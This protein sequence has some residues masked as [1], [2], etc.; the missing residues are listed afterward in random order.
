MVDSGRLPRYDELPEI[1]GTGERHAWEVFGPNDNLGTVN[2]L[3]AERV[4]AAMSLA[5]AGRVI[6]LNLPLDLPRPA[7]FPFRP[8][9]IH[10]RTANRGGGDD[11][12]DSFQM[13][14]S[15]QWDGLRHI[16]FREH[17]YYQGVQ[18][19][20]LGTDRL[21]MEH[22][23][24]HGIF[25]RAVLIDMPRYARE[26]GAYSAVERIAAD[27]PMIERIAARE[28]V[29]IREGDILLLRT[30]WVTWYRGLDQAAR[31]A[32][33]GTVTPEGHRCA[34]V[35]P[36]QAT[37]AWVWNHHLAAIVA[38]NPGLEALP[39]ENRE[40]QHR[41]FIAMLGMPLGE[42][43]DLDGLADDCAQDGVYEMFLS[44]APLH[45]PGGV[46]SPAN[47]YAIK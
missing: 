44:A 46:G 8:A 25:G 33:V 6:N 27:G 20:A 38:D 34:G 16:R 24:R 14:G 30:G 42:L 7:L 23:A 37:A 43:W 39:V 41:R 19:D 12:L 32:L 28:Q 13:Q 45:I 10:H 26:G 9:Y 11:Y 5:R 2:L 47:A 4:R 22:W 1:P 18:E 35:D 31:D 40:F 15:S 3:T 36:S 17:G 29:E 21:G